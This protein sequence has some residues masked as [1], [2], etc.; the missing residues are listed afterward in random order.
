LLSWFRVN[1][2]RLPWRETRDPYAILVS[3]VMLQ[4]TQVERVIPRYLGWL[5][6]WPTAEA[7]AAT[8]SADVIR[9][10]QGLGYN[11]RGLNLHRAAKHIAAYGW[12]DDLTELPGVGPYT[13]AAVGNFALG[14]SV[15]PVDTN[16]RRIEERTRHAFTP[17]AAQALMDL[18]ATV[19]LARVPRCGVCPLAALCPSRGRRYEP[20][21]KQSRFEG[22]FRQRRARTLRLVADRERPLSELDGDAVASLARDGLV[23]VEADVVA[24]PT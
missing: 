17:A 23:R 19:C 15:L 20:L 13:A 14:H 12:P 11:R 9:A 8:S 21:R 7:L 6:R 22:S 10:W 3:E 16:V 18:G 4:Q 24:L 2:R 5:Q 1:A